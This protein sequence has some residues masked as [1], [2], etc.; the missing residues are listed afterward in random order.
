MA[1]EMIHVKLMSVKDYGG[2]HGIYFKAE[3]K[4]INTEFPEFNVTLYDDAPLI[5]N[6]SMTT[7]YQFYIIYDAKSPSIL[8]LDEKL[9]DDFIPRLDKMCIS[10]SRNKE[11]TYEIYKTKLGMIKNWK[12]CL[13]LK[14]IK[15]FY[16]IPMEDYETL[17]SN[18]ELI[19]SETFI[20]CKKI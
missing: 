10:N 20:D 19:K 18:S 12:K 4:R 7:N 2:M 13:T 14:S 3:M 8:R 1:H 9:I 15:G 17:K 11:L 5:E 6:D 16:H